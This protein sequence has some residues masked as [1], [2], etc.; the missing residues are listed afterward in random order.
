[1]GIVGTRK[2]YIVTFCLFAEDA[3]DYIELSV[4]LFPARV[5]F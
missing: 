1:M 5:S 3:C 4:P 2:L